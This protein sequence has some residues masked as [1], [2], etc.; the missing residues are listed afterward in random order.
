MSITSIQLQRRRR[1]QPAAPNAQR[2]ARRGAAAVLAMMF[3]VLF[4]T[5]ALSMYGMS[6]I[7]VQ[8]ASN[9]SDADRAYSV[10]ESGLH[11]MSYR[12]VKM[13]RPKTTIGNI[14]AD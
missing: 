4:T 9:L 13:A 7:N 11:W 1:Q 3:L 6:S 2:P 5:L 14:T 8:T 10:A 12:F